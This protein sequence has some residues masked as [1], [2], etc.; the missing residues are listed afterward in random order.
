MDTFLATQPPMGW[1]GCQFEKEVRKI[2]FEQ[3]SRLIASAPAFETMRIVLRVVDLVA[4][5]HEDAA[6]HGPGEDVH[7]VGVDELLGLADA[8]RRLPSRRLP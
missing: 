8:D 1:Q 5:A 7:L 4:H 6:V 3:R 2:H